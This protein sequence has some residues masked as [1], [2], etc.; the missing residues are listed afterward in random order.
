M[1][2]DKQLIERTHAKR[3]IQVTREHDS[4]RLKDMIQG[5]A[6]EENMEDFTVSCLFD[7]GTL[8]LSLC[9]E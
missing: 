9:G 4:I 1:R 5:G 7:D 2:Q 6:N 8:R 3:V